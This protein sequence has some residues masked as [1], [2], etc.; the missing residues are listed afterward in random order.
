[1]TKIDFG[2]RNFLKA[3]LSVAL[4]LTL[5]TPAA[6]FATGTSTDAASVSSSASDANGTSNANGTKTVRV[7]WYIEEL[8]QEGSTDAEPKSGYSYDYLRK[9]ADYT[10]WKYEYVYGE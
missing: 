1:M 7:G 2:K 5:L 4:I 9:V 6:A 3:I 10:S 8:F